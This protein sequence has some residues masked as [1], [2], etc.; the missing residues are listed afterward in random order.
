MILPMTRL[1]LSFWLVL[2]VALVGGTST[3]QARPVTI[4]LG[5]VAPKQ[6]PWYKSVDAIGD[7]WKT[8]SKGQVRLKIYPGGVAGDESDMLRKIK[9]G[10]LHAASISGVG[11]GAVSRAT[12]A[13][14]IPMLVRS[15]EEL[16]YVREQ[17]SPLLERELSDAGFVVLNWGDAGWVHFFSTEPATTP[18]EFKNFKIMVFAK[19]PK[20]EEAW[21]A[22]AFNP[23]P[24][25]TTDVL[26]GLQT[27][28]ID[29]FATPPIF[30]LSAQ[31]FGLAKHMVPVKW[32]P[33]SGATVVSRER[34]EQIPEALRPELLRIAREEGDKSREQIRSLG[35]RAIEAMQQRG[36]VVHE[37]S[38]AQTKAWQDAAIAAYPAIRGQVVPEDVFD[39]VKMLAEKVRNGE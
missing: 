25:S 10:Q 33:L 21:K 26:Q 29:A 9:I 22:A 15:Y 16:D 1:R 32:T 38:P 20:A 34:W 4:K 24:L 39:R 18:G 12:L 37:L 11:L 28:L 27:G 14:Q 30:A 31:W 13:I 3:A 19:D 5:T 36:L 6:S 23:V 35:D 17:M 2:A 8:A 7:R